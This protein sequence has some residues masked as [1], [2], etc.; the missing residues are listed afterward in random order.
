MVQVCPCVAV[1]F[2]GEAQGEAWHNLFEF[3]D[4][5]ME[6]TRREWREAFLA[7]EEWRQRRAAREVARRI[8]VKVVRRKNEEEERGRRRREAIH[9]FTVPRTHPPHPQRQARPPLVHP[10][11]V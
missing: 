1:M 2:E 10:T 8:V 5:P 11:S 4:R 7:Q 9:L 3:L 6:E